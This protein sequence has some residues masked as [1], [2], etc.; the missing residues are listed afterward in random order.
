MTARD[1][2]HPSTWPRENIIYDTCYR[3]ALTLSW[4]RLLQ[5]CTSATS[6][7]PEGALPLG[8]DPESHSKGEP[9]Q[10][11][12]DPGLH[13]R[14]KLGSEVQSKIMASSLLGSPQGTPTQQDQA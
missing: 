5:V 10:R 8:S 11:Y 9:V 13:P 6:C 14:H 1:F 7:E 4:L 12:Q 3:Q 2:P